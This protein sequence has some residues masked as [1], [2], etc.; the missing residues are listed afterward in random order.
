MNF[1]AQ[2]VPLLNINNNEHMTNENMTK[3][4]HMTKMQDCRLEV[5]QFEL[6]SCFYFHFWTNILR[7]RYWNPLILHHDHFGLN[8][9]TAVLHEGFDIK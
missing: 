8:I 1:C 3:H 5:C 2:E 9:I 4:E 6:Q 7:E